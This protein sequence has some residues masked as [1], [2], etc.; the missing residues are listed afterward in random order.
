LGILDIVFSRNEFKS[1]A[2]YERII[3]QILKLN[4]PFSI[5]KFNLT[6]SGIEVKIDIPTEK[7]PEAT[8]ALISENI[9]VKKRVINIDKELCVNCGQCISLCNTGSLSFDKDFSL[10]FNE[11]KCVGCLLCIDACPVKAIIS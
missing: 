2:D 5:L 10:N 7:I 11:E 6:E 3:N 8:K 4:I 9:K 1:L